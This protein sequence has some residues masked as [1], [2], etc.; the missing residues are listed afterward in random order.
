MDYSTDSLNGDADIKG[1]WTT[2]RVLPLQDGR[3]VRG[4]S[5][6]RGEQ[7]TNRDRSPG[8]AEFEDFDVFRDSG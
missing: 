4:K 1:S 7:N 2:A 8:L 3:S 5:Y 6:R